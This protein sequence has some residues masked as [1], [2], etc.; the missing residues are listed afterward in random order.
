MIGKLSLVLFLML[1][2]ARSN[3]NIISNL[4]PKPTF[5][6]QLIDLKSLKSIRLNQEFLSRPPILGYTR[7]ARIRQLMRVR[8]AG[9]KKGSEGACKPVVD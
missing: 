1:S 3:R 6:I 5:L 2:V 4:P 7:F 8:I 9:L